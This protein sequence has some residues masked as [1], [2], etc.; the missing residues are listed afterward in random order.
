[1]SGFRDVFAFHASMTYAVDTPILMVI[2]LF[3]W[4]I[5]ILFWV[6]LF[7]NAAELGRGNIQRLTIGFE[8]ENVI[9]VELNE[10]A[11]E[12]NCGGRVFLRFSDFSSSDLDLKRLDHMVSILLSSFLAT[13]MIVLE[14]ADNAC[15]ARQITV[16]R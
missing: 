6:P 14:G 5:M 8:N 2:E 13:E 15:F 7:V 1:M 16:L 4:S 12:A 10:P 11:S 3:R 9:L